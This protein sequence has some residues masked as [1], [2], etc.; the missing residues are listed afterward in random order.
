MKQNLLYISMNVL[1]INSRIVVKAKAT[2]E[3][4]QD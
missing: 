1:K 3:P 2:I 4:I